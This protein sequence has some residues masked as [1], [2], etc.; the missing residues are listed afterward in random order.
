[1]LKTVGLGPENESFML[2]TFGLEAKVKLHDG[3]CWPR[4]K[5]ESFMHETFGLESKVEGS[6][7][8]LMS[9]KFEMKT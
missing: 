9:P 6:R 5:H 2:E 1:M 7:R 4:G 8:Q 3:N